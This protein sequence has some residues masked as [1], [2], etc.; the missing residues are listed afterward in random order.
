LKTTFITRMSW[1]GN[2]S[3]APGSTPHRVER[4]KDAEE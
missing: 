2:E 3:E 1:L 4:C